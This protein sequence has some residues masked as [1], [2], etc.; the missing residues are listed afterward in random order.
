M[1][2][3]TF[4]LTR[5]ELQALQNCLPK[6]ISIPG[7]DRYTS[8]MIFCHIFKITQRLQNKLFLCR[9]K[10]NSFTF[11]IPEACSFIILFSTAIINEGTYE[12]SVIQS[13]IDIIH[14][15]LT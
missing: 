5:S 15:K 10:N 1:K 11:S 2:K 14:Q 3:I 8:I 9:E 13:M 7:V 4:K 12:Q 6:I